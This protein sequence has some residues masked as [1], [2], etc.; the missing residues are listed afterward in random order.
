MSKLLRLPRQQS[1]WRRAGTKTAW[2]AGQLAAWIGL[3]VAA[4]AVA[5]TAPHGNWGAVLYGV[6]FAAVL[7]AGGYVLWH[8]PQAVRAIRYGRVPK[9]HRRHPSTD[10]QTHNLSIHALIRGFR[11]G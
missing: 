11:R 8:A 5:D 4:I 9:R 7:G 6:I 3:G 2:G 10:S 1:E